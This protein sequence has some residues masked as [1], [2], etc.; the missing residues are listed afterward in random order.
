MYFTELQ[1]LFKKHTQP[2]LLTVPCGQEGNLKGG[3]LNNNSRT[4]R[5]F[6]GGGL[7]LTWLSTKVQCQDAH[8]ESKELMPPNC[9]LISTPEPCGTPHLQMHTCTCVH[10]HT[11]TK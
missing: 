3:T 10:T 11:N 5:W 4:A 9:A 1:K 7:L 6:S 2:Q 8:G